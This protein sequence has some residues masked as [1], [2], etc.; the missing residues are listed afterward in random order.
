VDRAAQLGADVQVGPYAVI[1]GAARI[2]D[3]CLIRAHAI[4]GAEV[5]MGFDNVVGYGAVIGAEPQDLAFRQGLHTE[6]R[7]GNSN[8]I[9]EY[10]TIHRG[11]ADGSATVVGDRCFLMAGAHLGHNVR[12]GNSVIIANNAL[13]GGYVAIEDA[14]FIGGGSVFHQYVRVGRLAICQGMSAASKD[15]PPFTVAA[16]RNRVVGLNVVGLRR[17]GFSQEQRT[18]IK[19]AF[20][21]LYCESL[22]TTQALEAARSQS[23]GPE[24]AE[25]FGFVAASRKRGICALRRERTGVE[26][27]ATV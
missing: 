8:R 5:T 3:R 23:W 9:R 4:I 15:I 26:T 13:L 18:E 6:V 2:G 21:L 22:N 25:F 16:G 17:A 11:T 10:C 24:G 14:V 7:I 12:L 1:E 20:E 27:G 19:R